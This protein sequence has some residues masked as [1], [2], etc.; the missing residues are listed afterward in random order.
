M[1]VHI[2]NAGVAWA[3]QQDHVRGKE[4]ARGGKVGRKEKEQY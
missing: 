4:E 3:T 1:V 2:R